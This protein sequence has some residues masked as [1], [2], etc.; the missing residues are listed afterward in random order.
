MKLG[1]NQRKWLRALRSGKYK[2]GRGA[3]HTRRN[4]LCCLGVACVVMGAEHRA[5]NG[6]HTYDGTNAFLPSKIVKKLGLLTN[7]GGSNSGKPTCAELNDKKRWT[8]DEIA[9]YLV[10]HKNEYFERSR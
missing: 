5:E 2:Q 6:Y 7:S 9:D 1:P 4:H 3:L 10:K 8:F